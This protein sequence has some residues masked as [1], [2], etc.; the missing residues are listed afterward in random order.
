MED[1]AA[2]VRAACFQQSNFSASSLSAKMSEPIPAQSDSTFIT[3]AMWGAA[4]SLDAQWSNNAAA[5]S[6]RAG[7][8]MISSARRGSRLVL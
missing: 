5:Q 4:S 3:M 6:G 2:P 8:I 1:D 7:A